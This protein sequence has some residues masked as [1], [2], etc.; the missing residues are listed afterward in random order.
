MKSIRRSI[1]FLA[2]LLISIII[3]S[4]AFAENPTVAEFEQTT[5]LADKLSIQP[6]DSVALLLEVLPAEPEIIYEEV[7][8]VVYTLADTELY[9]EVDSDDSQQMLAH[10]TNLHRTGISEDWSRV[11]VSDEVFYVRND[12]VATVTDQRLYD[13]DRSDYSF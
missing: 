8:E 11:E 10:S 4:T 7:D 6:E 9:L 1:W 5:K 12:Q 13:I 2:L 3:A